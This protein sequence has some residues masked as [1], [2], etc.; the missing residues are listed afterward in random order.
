M[1]EKKEKNKKKSE[2]NSI[3]SINP[4][5]LKAYKYD[6]TELN[7]HKLTKFD[8]NNFYISYL[9]AKDVISTQIDISRSIPDEDIS[10]AVELKVYDELGLDP[11]IEYKIIHIEDI[12]NP[13]KERVFDV[14]VIKQEKLTSNFEQVIDKINYID[15]ITPSFF[16]PK[17][18]YKKNLL[19]ANTIDCFIYFQKEDAFLSIYDN[20]EHL[21]SKSL[22]YS[23]MVIYEKFCEL[24][25]ERVDEEEF[26]NLI[27]NEGLKSS[28][29]THQQHLMK[30][31]G[32]IFLY[33]NDVIVFAK[34]LYK[35][36]HIDRIFIGSEVGQIIGVE[37]YSRNYL[38][39]ESKEFNFS[40]AI[41]TRE[42]YID[43]IHVMLILTAL[44]Y[45]EEKDETL[46]LSIIKRPPPF[47]KRPS[48]QIITT[49]FAS[50]ILAL[51]Y[52][53]FQLGY[54]KYFDIQ[55]AWKE[56]QY[57]E[58]HKIEM[59]L[60][61]KL[62][63]LG[64]EKQNIVNS[65]IK[66]ENELNYRATILQ[67]IHSK[68]VNYNLKA[69][70]LVD[71]FNY[72]NDNRV[73]ILAINTKERDFELHV[74]SADDKQITQ[75]I[76]EIVD[77]KIYNVSTDLISTIEELKSNGDRGS[78]DKKSDTFKTKYK[79]RSTLLITI[80]NNKEEN[81]NNNIIKGQK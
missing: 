61:A 67:K 73:K 19:D 49:F 52:P 39:V 16:L 44:D 79:Y 20:G 40:I 75:M 4:V 42:W 30:L 46:N 57:N 14:Y 9:S 35:I 54:A 18:L 43:Q 11:A 8:K 65:I 55:R 77:D 13:S 7:L 36:E 69:K 72:A 81:L 22:R 70:V 41:N 5:D 62:T 25:G 29:I 6:N 1:A 38:G 56:K 74:A 34:R 78:K 28:N 63:K 3:I 68:K 26:F 64:K 51:I 37:E 59:D 2:F 12:D 53:G 17:S 60:K 21:Y 76:K 58:K 31:F 27:T 50:I 23:L 32:E 71:F 47:L 48:G 15:Y 33:I 45:L 10:D 80:L 24:M 66:E